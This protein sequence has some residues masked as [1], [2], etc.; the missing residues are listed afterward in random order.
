MSSQTVGEADQCEP[1][2]KQLPKILTRLALENSFLFDFL[3]SEVLH[4][5]KFYEMEVNSYQSEAPPEVAE[6]H[7]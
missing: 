4:A 3:K 6:R 1:K 7:G 2:W 5:E